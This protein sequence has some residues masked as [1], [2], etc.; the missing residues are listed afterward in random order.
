MTIAEIHITAARDL[1][2]M[3]ASIKPAA[4]LSIE[5]PDATGDGRAPRLFAEHGLDGIAQLVQTY[6]DTEE[7]HPQGPSAALVAEGLA[8]LQHHA[9]SGPVLVHCRQGKARSTGMA[10]AFMAASSPA[11]T[12]A[13]YIAY[14]K[15]IRPQA[16]PNILVVR[17]ADTVLNTG[18]AL[19][20]AVLADPDL[21][22]KRA[23]ANA[24]RA[25]DAEKNPHRIKPLPR[26]TL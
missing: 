12:A 7:E 4:V 19:E 23:Q 1:L 21:T 20:A 17:H 2:D 9:A 18:G 16:A 26:Q 3:V 10:L 25:R 15:K 14:L 13:D 5:H 8:F 6:W 24:S 22:A 11:H